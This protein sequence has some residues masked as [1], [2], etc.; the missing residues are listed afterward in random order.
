MSSSKCLSLFLYFDK[1][2]SVLICCVHMPTSQVAYTILCLETHQKIFQVTEFS[3][4]SPEVMS[5]NTLRASG[6]S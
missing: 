5:S 2:L 4:C 6:V 1:L 3:I